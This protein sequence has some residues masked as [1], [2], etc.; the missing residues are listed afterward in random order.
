MLPTDPNSPQLIPSWIFEQDFLVFL[1]FFGW[2]L[3]GLLALSKP[4]SKNGGVRLPWLWIGF[5]AFSQAVS[6]FLRTLSFSDEFFRTFNLEVG[7]E[8]LGY[9]LL[10]EIA[11][12]YAKKDEGRNL[13][14][15]SAL[16]GLFL[17]LSIEIG[18][19][20]YTLV[21]S[22]LVSAGAVFWACRVFARAA[23]EEGRR[24]LYVIV[25]GL[26]LLFPTWL[27]APGRLDVVLPLETV[28]YED[29]PYYG[30]DLLLLRIVA[31]WTILAGF[32]YYRLQRRIEDVA[33]QIASQL[34]L[35]GHR[36]LPVALTLVVGASFLVTSWNGQRMK[37][38]MS[39]DYLSRVQTAAVPMDVAEIG[40]FDE[41]IEEGRRLEGAI[42]GQFLGIKRVGSDVRSVY[43][44]NGDGELIR[45]AAFETEQSEQPFL[46][47][48]HVNLAAISGYVSGEAFLAGPFSIGGKSLM[49][50]SAPIRERTSGEIAYWLGID[51]SGAS[52]FRNV[53]L[54]RLQTIIIAGLVMALVIFFLY[55]QI[56]HESE[57]D[58]ILAKERA[59]AGDRAKSEFLAVISHEIRTPLQSVLGYSDLLKST[60]LDD[61]QRACLDTIQSEGKI[62]LRIVQDILDFSNL[63]KANFQLEYGPVYLRH[64]IEETFRTIKPM[65]DRKGLK[66][67]LVIMSEVPELVQADGVRLRQVLLN[68]FGNSVKYTEEGEVFLKAFVGGDSDSEALP[69][70]FEI[71]DTGVGIKQEDLIRLFEPFIQLEHSSKFPREG[72]GL[73]LAIVN[74]IVELMG[75]HINVQSEVG[76]GSRFTASF[77]FDVLEVEESKEDLFLSDSQ[78]EEDSLPM[79]QLYP[80]KILV[81]DDNPMVRRLILQ[82]LEAL[83]YEADEFDGGQAAADHGLEYDVLIMDL[84]MPVMDGPTAASRIREKGVAAD[85]PWIVAV[86]ASLQED[87][88][89]RA[90]DAGVNDFL[91]KPFYAGQLGERIEAIPWIEEKRLDPASIVAEEEVVAEPEHVP[92]FIG[93]AVVEEPEEEVVAEPVAPR[94]VFGGID[95]YPEEAVKAAIAEV[96]SKLGDMEAGA[97]EG[98]W[99]MVKED[100]HYLAN[101]AM[102]LGI[103]QLYLDSKD[104]ENAALVEDGEKV[105]KG[106]VEL[107]LNFEAWESEE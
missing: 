20:L 8:M 70:N 6:D 83:G 106:L 99:F 50:L 46:A 104:V 26:V 58:L 38:R 80:L 107:K 7:F 12:R 36:V 40:A 56:E 81:V 75:G 64:L 22:L 105:K 51:V 24:E 85:R 2:M 68:L 10:V 87:E 57:S 103:D 98:D 82:Y 15:Y 14:P 71:L 55:Y 76:K 11:I 100:A 78:D 93:P 41:I 63:R 92:L 69:L 37:S 62:L 28:S 79:G 13:F 65:A 102:A 101:T 23:K 59:E 30:F 89:K 52:W 16:G 95:S 27:L 88:V 35:W 42:A 53:S 94:T 9:G 34:R 97:A 90:R 3:V 86:S 61:K 39:Q 73:G 60:R 44:W 29:F 5:Y 49:H 18:D 19:L 45:T 77:D 4:L 31:G 1:S 43:L 91:G 96:Y 66:A 33:P 21:V 67:H 32:W 17:G 72:A 84:R 47:K 25:A 54:S 48:T 74:R